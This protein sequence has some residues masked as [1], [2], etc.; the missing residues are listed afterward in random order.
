[1]KYSVRPQ[2]L[3]MDGLL[4]PDPTVVAVRGSAIL[5]V[6]GSEENLGT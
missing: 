4:R 3:V 5:T 2:R 6:S 1:M